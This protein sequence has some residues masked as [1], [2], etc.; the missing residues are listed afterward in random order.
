MRLIK[1]EKNYLELQIED[2]EDLWYLSRLINKN[3]IVKGK[4]TRKIKINEKTV[5][6]KTYYFIIKVEK[7]E[8]QNEQLKI[9]GTIQNEIEDIPKGSYQS[10]H[11]K[12]GDIIKIEKK[13]NVYHEK[14]LKTI[15]EK[16][17]KTFLIILFDREKA[18]FFEVTNT[19]IKK[20]LELQGEVE[21][22]Q[23]KT[24]KENFYKTII[25]KAE[26]KDKTKKYDKI[27]FSSPQFYQ[28]YLKKELENNNI[29]NKSIII[30]VSGT[31]KNSIKEL[32]ERKEIQQQILQ[33]KNM[34]ETKIVEELLKNISKG[35]KYS[36]GYKDV[37]KALEYN[38]VETLII[39]TE[40]INKL[41]E[42][43][44]FEKLNELLDNYGK[45]INIEIIET[46]KES[47]QKITSLGGI[48]AIL[49]YDI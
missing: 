48:T 18:N 25:E 15:L 22:K 41:L 11:F 43:D 5:E 44:E 40:Y 49:R 34:K 21:K 31:E 19:N 7:T 9:N 32:L 37:K 16:N 46:D 45:N 24:K 17:K 27:I 36:Y 47:I 8:Y 38:A 35:T 23:Y 10:I 2:K 28:E 3:D 42:K 1:K 39:S 26:E 30:T 33:L 29:K 4:S 13:L 14:I 20:I 6:K 12:E